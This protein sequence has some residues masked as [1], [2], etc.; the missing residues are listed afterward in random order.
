[1]DRVE[2]LPLPGELHLR[3]GRMHVGIHQF[4]G[5]GQGQDAAGE[6]SLHDLVPIPLF[7]SGAQ[8]RG[9]DQASVDE[10]DLHGP[11]SPALERARH[12]TGHGH[13]PHL[14][15][16]P[17][18]GQGEVPAQGGVHGGRQLP[19]PGGPQGLRAVLHEAERDLG[20]GQ[21]QT[22]D[23]PAHRRRLRAVLAQE[24]G[25]GRDVVEQVL[26][27]DRGPLRGPDLLHLPR[28]AP[29]QTQER[30]R[31]GPLLP[32]PDLHPGHGGDRGQGLPTEA[33][34]PDP[35]QIVG[36]AELAGGVAQEG[37][38]D[39]VGGDAAAVVR[40]PDQG[41]AAPPDRYRD[42]GR[43]RVHRVLH[44]LLD[45]AGGTLHHLPGGDQF[46][47][48]LVQRPDVRHGSTSLSRA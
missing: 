32:G 38:G 40:D 13:V 43:P 36:G 47:Q 17:D 14:P 9:L 44:Q 30:P 37:G 4:G 27:G 45:H 1:M 29:F 2:D 15:L 33:Q 20:A 31:G 34:G 11:G 39:L 10:E 35:A 6:A 23:Q 19:V 48:M 24:L 5:H 16:R 28:D 46:R 3:L 25:P 26:D 22:L 18:Q 12:Q 8:E 42:G 21:G 41:R 7:Q